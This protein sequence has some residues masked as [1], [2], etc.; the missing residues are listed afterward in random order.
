MFSIKFSKLLPNILYSLS[1]TRTGLVTTLLIRH[2]WS[3]N[4]IL[5]EIFLSSTTENFT[6]AF[7][8]A[9]NMEDGLKTAK[10][11]SKPLMLVV[12]RYT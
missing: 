6:N 1:L 9:K 11:E 12:H 8:F 7:K 2:T 3:K 5:I 10:L 4:K